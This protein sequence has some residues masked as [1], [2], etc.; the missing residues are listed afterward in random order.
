MTDL[1]KRVTELRAKYE[2][3]IRKYRSA[4]DMYHTE[5]MTTPSGSD[6]SR[7]LFERCER[8]FPFEASWSAGAAIRHM[9]QIDSG[10]AT[11]FG[12]E[13]LEKDIEIWKN[14]MEKLEI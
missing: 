6:R 2:E 5:L 14:E 11:E 1:E 10:I 8:L 3:P 9:D 12:Y 7:K 4:L 13:M